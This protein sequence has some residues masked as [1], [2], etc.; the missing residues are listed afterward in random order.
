MTIEQA[1]QYFK[2]MGAQFYFDDYVK[3]NRAFYVPSRS[4]WMFRYYFI[5]QDH[6]IGY[7]TI[8]FMDHPDYQPQTFEPRAWGNHIQKTLEVLK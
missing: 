2:A 6:D 8:P 1:D 4:V 5:D 7:V 3:S